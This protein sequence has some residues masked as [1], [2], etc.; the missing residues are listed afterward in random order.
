MPRCETIECPPMDTLDDTR[1]QLLEYNN[2][3]GGRVVFACMW[4]NKLLGSQTIDCQGDGSWSE[5]VP[6]CMGRHIELARSVYSPGQSAYSL[7]RNYMPD[8]VD[9]EERPHYGANETP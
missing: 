5:A 8:S 2:T 7:S 6:S 1:L 4:G 3:F 9:T